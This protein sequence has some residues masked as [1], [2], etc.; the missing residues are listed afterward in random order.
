MRIGIDCRLWSQTGVGRYIRELVTRLVTNHADTYVLFARPEDVGDMQ[1]Q[2]SGNRSVVIIETDVRWHTLKEQLVFP[3]SIASSRVELMHFPYFS[4]PV[5]CP[6]PYVITVHDMIYWQYPTGKASTLHPF[7]YWCKQLAYRCIVFI[8]TRRARHLIAVSHATKKA[9]LDILHIPSGRVTV[10]YEGVSHGDK[11][12]GD[13]T[14]LPSRL[15]EG[16]FLMTV[17]NA[18]PHKNLEILC[19]AVVSLKSIPLLVVGKPTY[20]TQ[21]LQQR[22]AHTSWIRFAGYVDDR[23]LSGLYAHTAGVVVPSLDEGFGFP[24]VEALSQGSMV[25]C[26]EIPVLREVAGEAPYYFDP[27]DVGSITQALKDMISATPKE[28]QRRTRLFKIH[29]S[30]FSWDT[31]AEKTQKIYHTCV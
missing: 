6:V 22:Y 14:K 27:R 18:Y 17:G 7:F 3:L 5:C 11:R 26:S 1:R 2:F 10:L 29:A 19:D 20:F 23:V 4:V 9:V 25:A 24:V 16:Q 31:M 8:T 30:Q 13:H 28:K 12:D 21:R 15:K